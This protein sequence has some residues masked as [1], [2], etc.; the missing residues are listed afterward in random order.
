MGLMNISKMKINL[1]IAF[2]KLKCNHLAVGSTFQDVNSKFYRKKRL[3]QK[4]FN[5]IY[6]FLNEDENCFCFASHRFIEL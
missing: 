5:N 4:T 6:I 1:K 3:F 2:R